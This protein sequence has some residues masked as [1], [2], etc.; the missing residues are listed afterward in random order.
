MRQYEAVNELPVDVMR[1]CLVVGE[2]FLL[3]TN[4]K[5]ETR[6]LWDIRWQV[7]KSFLFCLTKGTRE[8]Y[9]QTVSLQSQ[10]R[11]HHSRALSTLLPA[12]TEK[13][14]WVELW[15]PLS[16]T[17]S[18]Y[19]RPQAALRHLTIL[20]SVTEV[21]SCGPKWPSVRI[22]HMRSNCLIFFKE[23]VS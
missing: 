4:K 23:S 22:P 10:M 11:G 3:T 18:S 16:I 2:M 6:K 1:W 17:T 7:A 20:S 8:L 5:Y 12:K 19:H 9:V 14:F 13:M 21:R 15:N